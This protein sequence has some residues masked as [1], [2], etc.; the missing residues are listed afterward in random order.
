MARSRPRRPAAAAPA[1]CCAPA[2]TATGECYLSPAAHYSV[3]CPVRGA[4]CLGAGTAAWRPCR[5]AS[6]APT[7]TT[8]GTRYTGT[9][10]TVPSSFLPL[11]F[12][13]FIITN[14]INKFKIQLLA[15][16]D[17]P[18]EAARRLS[19]APD[20]ASAL[21]VTSP[22][23]RP[24]PAAPTPPSAR[25]SRSAEGVTYRALLSIT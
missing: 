24:A 17:A 9:L 10:Q 23:R 12:I 11:S 20:P 1:R 6:A 22:P 19:A 8:A 13:F 2:I 15:L 18:L 25:T 3:L 4:R 5:P 14:I 21:T 7:R 16:S